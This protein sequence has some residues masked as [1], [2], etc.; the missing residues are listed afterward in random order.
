MFSYCNDPSMLEGLAWDALGK[1]YQT[2]S[3]VFAYSARVAAAVGAMRVAECRRA[4]CG[5]GRRR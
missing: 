3:G 1:E 2:L 5:R 4:R